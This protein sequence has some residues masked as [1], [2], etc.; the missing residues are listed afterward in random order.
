MSLEGKADLCFSGQENLFDCISAY[1][2]TWISLGL[3]L[4]SH[5]FNQLDGTK[6]HRETEIINT[7]VLLTQL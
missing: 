6:S 2:G 4:D 1:D 3:Q 7:N 5:E